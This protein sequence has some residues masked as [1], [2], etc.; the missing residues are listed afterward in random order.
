[1]PDRVHPATEN[2]E[3]G[4]QRIGVR[5]GLSWQRAVFVHRVKNRSKNGQQGHESDRNHGNRVHDVSMARVSGSLLKVLLRTRERAVQ[6]LVGHEILASKVV[7]CSRRVRKGL[8]KRHREK[9]YRRYEYAGDEDMVALAGR[10]GL[11]SGGPG[12]E[13]QH[14]QHEAQV[15]LRYEAVFGLEAAERRQKVLLIGGAPEAKVVPRIP[16]TLVSVICVV[17]WLKENN[18]VKC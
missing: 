12:E 17:G 5:S 2:G 8:A 6:L 10:E 13:K 16:R 18:C 3:S 15:E 14:Q 1:M 7:G 11:P 4:R 9:E